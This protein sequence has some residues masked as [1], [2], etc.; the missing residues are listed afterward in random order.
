MKKELNVH[1]DTHLDLI[2]EVAFKALAGIKVSEMNELRY[3]YEQDEYKF[4]NQIKLK[5]V[6]PLGL[7]SFEYKINHE[8]ERIL[9]SYINYLIHE[10]PVKKTDN[11]VQF[12][13]FMVN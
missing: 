5:Y 11:D 8:V 2:Q 9:F 3:T 12:D 4:F 10:I 1:L 13:E 7:L 6:L